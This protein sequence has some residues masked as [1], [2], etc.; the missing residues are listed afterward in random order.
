MEN[1]TVDNMPSQAGRLA[2][3]TGANSGLGYE[4]ALA[5]AKKGAEVIM[6]CR[7]PKKGQAAFDSIKSQVPQAKLELMAL[8]LGNLASVQAFANAFRDKYS[9]LD[10][11]LNNAGV[12]A[13]PRTESVDG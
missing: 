11:L 10:I 8:D 3:V 2:I 13:I 6:A 4:S 5:L 12:M 9:R 1:W 7:N